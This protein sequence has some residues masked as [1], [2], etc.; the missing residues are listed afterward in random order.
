MNPKEL[1]RRFTEDSWDKRSVAVL[2][3]ILSSQFVDHD[4]VPGQGPGREGYTQMA[5]S[6]F[7]AFPD[8]RVRNEDVFAEG[9]KAVLRWTAEGTHR[10][11]LMGI[12][13]T[14]RR[15]R[16]KGMDIIRVA[17]DKI[18]ERWGEFDALG[19]MQQLGVVPSGS[20]S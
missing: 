18:V 5:G 4:A 8:L 2:N 6:F 19:M 15:V 9:D 10:G 7:T 16:L 12:P 14:G 3:E 13:A 1:A 20:A 17:D 11:E